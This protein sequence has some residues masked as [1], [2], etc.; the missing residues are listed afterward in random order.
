MPSDREISLI[1]YTIEE[2]AQALRMHHTTVRSL[3]TSGKIRAVKGGKSW[4]IHPDSIAE[5]MRTGDPLDKPPKPIPE[6]A[7]NW[8]RHTDEEE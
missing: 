3:V 5:W 1:G 8:G 7:K 4:L 6:W 2:A